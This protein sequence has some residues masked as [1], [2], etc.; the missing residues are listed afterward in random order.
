MRLTQSA[1]FGSVNLE[2]GK[3]KRVVCDDVLME[4]LQVCAPKREDVRHERRSNH[5]YT[6]AI[7][8]F[9]VASFGHSR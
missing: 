2:V 7:G 3:Q 4:D 6:M 9:H 1:A 8:A 5:P